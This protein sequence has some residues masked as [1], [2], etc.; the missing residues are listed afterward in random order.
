MYILIIRVRFLQRIQHYF[1][2]FNFETNKNQASKYFVVRYPQND[3]TG[4]LKVLSSK[5][6]GGQISI[7]IKM[8]QV[9]HISE[10]YSLQCVIVA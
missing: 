8:L 7:V 5:S 10:A 9:T 1:H 6:F 3:T 4:T 2:K